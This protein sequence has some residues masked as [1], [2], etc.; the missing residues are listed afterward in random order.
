MSKARKSLIA[1]VG[2]I[3]AAAGG[4]V[5]WHYHDA[6]VVDDALSAGSME[7]RLRAIDKLAHRNSE[8]AVEALLELSHS[9]NTDIAVRA[10][11]AMGRSEQ[12]PRY[13]AR[14]LE[15][16]ESQRSVVREAAVTAL[17]N[18]GSDEDIDRLGELVQS[19]ASPIVR[20]RAARMLGRIDRWEGFD[21]LVSALNDPS[22]PVRAEACA[23][24]ERKLG[25]GFGYH[26]RIS[27]SQ[28]TT[29]ISQLRESGPKLREAYEDY[30]RRKEGG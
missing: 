17:G 13:R 7:V 23:G 20:A 2:G 30:H 29:I 21:D 18:F 14:V 12:A 10:I 9:E 16:L 4:V 24:I 19:A 25:R 27:A 15:A 8:A 6:G 28:R 26:P 3:L 5:A 22:L 1:V 11:H